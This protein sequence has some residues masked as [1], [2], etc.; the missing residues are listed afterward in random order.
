[1]ENRKSLAY[2]RAKKKVETL[3]GFY[4]HLVVYI[5]VN[6]AIILVTAN[7]FNDK[8]IDFADWGHYGTAFF[9][10]FGIVSHAIYVFYIMNIENNI[11]KRWE[12]KKIKQFLEEDNL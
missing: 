12:E 1:M 4:S 7:V 2:L 11:F 8:A 5:L 10:G 3:K 9:W 6:A